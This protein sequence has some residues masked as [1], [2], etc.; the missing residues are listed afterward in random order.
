[1]KLFI[2]H[3]SIRIMLIILLCG[4]ISMFNITL[5][6]KSYVIGI[7]VG[8]IVYVTHDLIDKMYRGV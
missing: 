4:I 1:M 7:I 8:V 6:L 2:K 3:A 5:E